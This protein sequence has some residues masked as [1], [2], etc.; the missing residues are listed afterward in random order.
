M[1]VGLNFILIFSDQIFVPIF[2]TFRFE[3]F[4]ICA[5]KKRQ[6][7][8]ALEYFAIK[9]MVRFFLENEMII[10]KKNLSSYQIV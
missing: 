7:F 9:N 4:F 6:Y 1:Q 2:K 3:A 5:F 8:L 10:L